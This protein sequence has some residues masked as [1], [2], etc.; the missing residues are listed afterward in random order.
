MRTGPFWQARLYSKKKRAFITRSL[1]TTD[2]TEATSK[3]I[4]LWQELDPLIKADVPL[5]S[6]SVSG[7]I[8]EYLECP[9]ETS[10]CRAD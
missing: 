6:T 3:A 7:S 1:K 8:E 9:A 4:Q 2:V 10:E 5:E